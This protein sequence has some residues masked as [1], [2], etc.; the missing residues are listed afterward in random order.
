MPI[1]TGQEA[2]DFALFDTSK[3]KV[4]LHDYRGRNVVLLFFPF[5]FSSTCTK[6]LCEM[7][8]NYSF[9]DKLNTEIIGISVD[10][11]YTNKKYKEEY[12]LNFPLLSD[13]NKEVSTA[14]DSL[15]DMPHFDYRGVSKRSSFVIDKN[16][17]I[18]YMEILPSAGDYPDMAK[19][20][21]V[22]ASLN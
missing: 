8:D 13:F 19:L 4:A 7:R 21:E 11:L 12:Q 2:P 18:A 17:K 16:G 14:Y 5:A 20:K 22:I 9:Y 1:S 10:S 6:E 15:A 3:K